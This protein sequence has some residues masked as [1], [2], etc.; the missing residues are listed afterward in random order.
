[1]CRSGLLQEYT[2]SWKDGPMPDNPIVLENQ[3]PGAPR[4]EWDIDG[5][6]ST[7]IN[8][9][10]TRLSVNRGEQVD[11]KI[12]TASSDY[13][14][15][16]YRLGY[17]DGLGAR[18]VETIRCTTPSIQP[19]AGGDPSIGLWDAGTWSVTTSWP[20]PATAV[21][22]VYVAKLVRQDGIPGA[23]HIPFVVRDDGTPRD[24][25][26]QTSDTTWHA[27]NGWGGANFYGGNT[28]AG[29]AYKVSY[30]RPF[31][32][33]D[34]IGT[35]A[36]PQDYV[37]GPEYAAIRWLEH[38]GYD[39]AY[40][41]GVDVGPGNIP[42]TNYKIFVS[43][44]HD[45]Y[46]AGEQR[47][48]VEA[49][50]DAGVNL[51]FFSGN[52]MYWKTRWEPDLNGV[53]NRTLVCYKETKTGDKIDPSPEWT[54][55]WRDPTFSP[56]SDG[57]R[58]EN[59]LTGTI[60]QVDSHQ[61][62][63]IEISPE[64]GRLRFWRDSGMPTLPPDGMGTLERG[65]LGYEW[66][67]SP[68]NE[69]RPPG[70]ITLSSTTRDV[71]DK[72]ILDYGRTGGTGTVTHHLTLYRAASGALVFGAGTVFWSFGLDT[73]HDYTSSDPGMAA[74]A[75]DRDAQQA[76][77]NLFADMGVQPQT[78]QDTLVPA[79]ASTD[80]TAPTTL[81]TAPANGATVVQ[82]SQVTITGTASDVDGVVAAV[83]VSTDDGA[84]W[85]A[86]D[87]TTS[88]TFDWWP[89]R[90]GT[91]P[92]RA[93][94]IDD[95]VN[96]ESPGASRTITVTPAETASLFTPNDLPFGVRTG[97]ANSV[98][99]GI[100]FWANTP[101]SVTGVRFYKNPSDTGTHTARLWS[102]DGTQLAL[103]TFTDESDSGWQRVDFP[104]P[105][106]ITP[107]TMYVASYHTNGLNCAD[108]N[109][110]RAPRTSGPLTAPAGAGVF[111]YGT[112][113]NFPNQSFT[114][115]NYWVDVE[116]TREGGAGNLA[117]TAAPKHALRTP[118]DTPLRIPAATLLAGDTDPNGYPLAVTSTAAAANGTV[119]WDPGART[120]TFTPA[121]GYAG[122][123]SF[124]YTVTNGFQTATATASLNVGVPVASRTL[125]A[126][127][128][129]PAMLNSVD[130]G[131]VELGM[132]FHCTAVGAVATGIRFYKGSLNT[133]P[134]TGRL[135]TA[136]GVPLATATFDD[137]TA[138]GWQTAD[139]PTP[140]PL[141]PNTPYVVSYHTSAKY[142]VTNNAFTA[143]K[144]SG[145][146]VA[147]AGNGWFSYGPPGSFPT[148]TFNATNYFVDIVASIPAQPS[149]ATLFQPEDLPAI[150]TSTDTGPIELGI[151]FDTTA[152]T[153]AIGIAFYK[154]PQNTGPHTAHLW[155]AA[156]APLATATFTAESATGWQTALFPNPIP[157]SPNTSYLASYH[158]TTRYSATS[159][160]FSTP[161]TAGTLTVSAPNGFF[162][163][164]P[165]ASFP[166][167]TFNATN[168]FVDI[169]TQE[170]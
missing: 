88:W 38:N 81:I 56:P 101:G 33:R 63:T 108:A 30:N 42:L 60:F 163:Y 3:R 144:T 13:R 94:A 123:A 37:F 107:G 100:R 28:A 164:G 152:P 75:E 2:R 109:Y 79:T 54:G 133:G 89:P 34:G 15:D 170:T 146:L 147:P 57:G 95:S 49:A 58:P 36:G 126:T 64:H 112:T 136:G 135:W 52:E 96:I 159:G 6:S 169:I 16:I 61:A 127:A 157:L 44:G 7:T 143:T 155:T 62:D 98:E 154:G 35:D 50:R 5:P 25:V 69:F 31:G 153:N 104:D 116:F 92:I 26:F 84:T 73:V 97:D 132:R 86:A 141:S 148:S 8:G 45:E 74:V 166:T 40:V 78:L 72:V 99:L 18:K 9:F 10:T 140:V 71:P 120:A 162:T 138:S 41:S 76:T 102:I 4:D 68:N 21:S 165:P 151:Q 160:S 121:T 145:A 119:T 167:S 124:R 110:F 12:D 19:P 93:R 23:S 115:N 46:W 80:T 111:A 55:T 117:P 29:R 82:Q 67:T 17:Y 14:I 137:E 90:A 22:G 27:Y 20:V 39:V 91:H 24:I 149:T 47:A 130:T 65:M 106:P 156:G 85:R 113:P 168:Y 105:V 83:E 11:F 59:S 114:N 77:V 43:V 161:K 122:P 32:T 70:L 103:A 158:T 66:D 53:P 48:N 129:T 134:H 51:C 118:V 131:P 142:S 128:D 139:F 150:V 125:F 1:M 87:G